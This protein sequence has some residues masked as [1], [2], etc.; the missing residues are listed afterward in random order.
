MNAEALIGTVLGRC[1]LQQVIGQGGMG[2]VYLAQ[3]TRPRRQV[4]VKVLLPITP[5]E[6]AAAN[7]SPASEPACRL[8]RTLPPRNG[9][10]RFT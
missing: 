7:H 10:C 8:P 6:S 5:R 9:C 4:A 3:Q 2:A 1:K